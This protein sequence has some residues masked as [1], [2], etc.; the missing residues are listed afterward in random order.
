[1]SPVTLPGRVRSAGLSLPH[2]VSAV[3]SARTALDRYLQG[4]GIEPDDRHDARLVLS[5]LISN[6]IRHAPPLA[7]GDLVVRWGLDPENVY[8]EVTD[9]RGQ[10]EPQQV[11]EVH[12]G[13]IG[14]RGLAIV[15][16]LT[17]SWG[18]R[19]DGSDRTVYAVL[20]R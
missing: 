7:S 11:N 19:M 18:V 14:G 15:T 5:E 9:G 8:L 1:V 12:P 16:V 20:P 17:S 4:Y 2:E 6:A 3:G 10:T 13:A